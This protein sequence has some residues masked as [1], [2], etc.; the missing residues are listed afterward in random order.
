MAS[1][2]CTSRPIARSCN[3]PSTWAFV[4]EP[5][6]NRHFETI[7]ELDKAVGERCVALTQQQE[8]ICASTLCGPP[9]G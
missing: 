3:P 2:W 9:Q 1:G 8:M 6:V 4:D 7:E 5:L